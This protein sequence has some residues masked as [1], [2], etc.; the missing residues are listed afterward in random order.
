MNTQHGVILTNN[1]FENKLE[2]YR[3]FA[4]N[5]QNS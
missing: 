3:D 4:C 1:I 2:D 5:F